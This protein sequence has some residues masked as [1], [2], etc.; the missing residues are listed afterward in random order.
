MISS[1]ILNGENR[2]YIYSHNDKSNVVFYVGKGV[3]NRAWQRSNRNNDWLEKAKDGYFV[4]ILEHGL[5][6]KEAVNREMNYIKNYNPSCNK[7]LPY[8]E[9]DIP[10]NDIM[11]AIE[12]SEQSPS[13]LVWRKSR[14][15]AGYLVGREY[16][17]WA[18]TFKKRQYYCHRVIM[19]LSSG[20]N[21]E[22]VVDHIDGNPLNNKISNLRRVSRSENSLNVKLKE[23]H[24]ITFRAQKYKSGRV[25]RR[26]VVQWTEEGVQ[27]SKAFCVTKKISENESKQL[28]LKFRDNLIKDNRIKVR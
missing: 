28:A 25:D 12:Y 8:T 2:Y 20:E 11:T 18:L 7:V 1:Q 23:M 10:I 13:G 21:S 17:T 6:E 4:F 16:K 24:H 9:K 15:N 27:K 14:K 22:K 3:N 19:A 26:F 5:S